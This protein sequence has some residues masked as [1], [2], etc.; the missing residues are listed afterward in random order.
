MED[1]WYTYEQIISM[2]GICKQTLYNWRKNGII[3]YQKITKKT[4]M[5]Q[6][7]ETKNIQENELSKN[8]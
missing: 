3:R 8:L 1:H 4:Y 7:P 2:F 5:Y 6:L